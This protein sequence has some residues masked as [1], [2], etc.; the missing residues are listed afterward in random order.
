METT[1]QALGVSVLQKQAIL[2]FA[3]G[4]FD[5]QSGQRLIENPSLTMK[6][7]VRRVKTYQLSKRAC[8]AGRNAI[9]VRFSAGCD[10]QVL[11]RWLPYKTWGYNLHN[12]QT[13]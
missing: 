3:F 6:D 1:H 10:S 2:R 12:A 8:T 7:E 13:P 4:I 11:T 5:Q 9:G